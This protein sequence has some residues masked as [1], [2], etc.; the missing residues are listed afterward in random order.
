VPPAP[1]GGADAGP[2]PGDARAPDATSLLDG[3]PAP[4]GGPL[5][6]PALGDA[7]GGPGPGAG[8]GAGGSPAATGK[9]GC[10]CALGGRARVPAGAG[11]AC[12]LGLLLLPRRRRSAARRLPCLLL[13]AAA[14][15]A[16]AGTLAVGPG[17]PYP[18]PCAAIA[19]AGNGD[20]IEIDAAGNYA[21]DVCG[22]SKN[23]LTLR[24]VGGRPKIDAA[25]RNAAGKG[26]WVIAGNDTTIENVELSGAKVPDQN[27]AAIR[28]EGNNLT[29]RDSYLH[30]NE[31]GILTG[32]GADSE[33]LI[34]RCEFA[35]N[36]FGDGFSH[37]MYIGKVKR[38]TLRFSYSHHARIGHNVK[39][40]AL[41]N[42]ILYN[43]ISDEADGTASYAVDLSNGGRS[44]LIGNLLQQGPRTDNPII[45]AYAAEGAS[46]GSDEL[47]VVNNTFVNDLGS[48]GFIRLGTVTTPAVVRNNV[49]LGAGTVI[50]QA[51]AVMASNFT[52]DP[53]LVDRAGYDY[54][55]RPGS[56]C[57]NAGTDPGV[58]A[59]VP[60]QPAFQYVHRASA[61]ARA[62]IGVI[63]IGA[64]ELGGGGPGMGPDG[65]ADAR[66]ASPDGAAPVD[67]P[68]PDGP[69]PT[70]PPSSDGAAAGDRA[71]PAADGPLRADAGAGPAAPAAKGDGCACSLGRGEPQ[72]A[73]PVLLACALALAWIRRRP[74]PRRPRPPAASSQERPGGRNG[75]FPPRSR[76]SH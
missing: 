50:N 34:E 22:W 26:I 40:R 23:G 70:G 71:L 21:G 69:P 46:N 27:G 43:R 59:G 39:S 48:G 2:R 35:S 56:P 3:A 33:I 74:R 61:E 31:D 18:A 13:L 55:L 11:V 29:L 28:Q 64:Y 60:L 24:G 57:V 14:G 17:K 62:A 73:G 47:F 36:G 15:R 32:A 75:S 16:Q 9:G 68:R 6:A 41:E 51:T 58:G 8:G 63:D 52:G 67:P 4:D 1:D 45:V 5:D 12:A 37:N 10:G 54:H 49:F 20:T 19:A 42:H 25:G 65:G 7:A 30:D 44:Y 66:P 53:M 38:F 72:G 76:L